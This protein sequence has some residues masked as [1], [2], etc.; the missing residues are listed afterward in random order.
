MTV[1]EFRALSPKRKL[2]FET[3]VSWADSAGHERVVWYTEQFNIE[4]KVFI[5]TLKGKHLLKH[6]I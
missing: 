3:C 6:C 5:P 2:F 4:S 1:E